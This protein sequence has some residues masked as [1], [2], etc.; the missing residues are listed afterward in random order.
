MQ[1]SGFVCIIVMMGFLS[2]IVIYS[3]MVFDADQ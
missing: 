3:L 1:E 2:A